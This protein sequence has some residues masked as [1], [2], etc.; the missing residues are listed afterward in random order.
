MVLDSHSI[1]VKFHLAPSTRR[2]CWS[3]LERWCS[4]EYNYTSRFS[5]NTFFFMN[6]IICMLMSESINCL[7]FLH[8]LG[9]H[10]KLPVIT[11]Y[12]PVQVT[13]QTDMVTVVV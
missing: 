9:F 11:E 5:Y 2:P 10:L 1:I 4:S 8:F 6:Y 3:V 13:L 12:E 7:H